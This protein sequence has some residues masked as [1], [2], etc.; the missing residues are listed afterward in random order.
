MI[1]NIFELSKSKKL[2]LALATDFFLLMLVNH[3]AI[4]YTFRITTEGSVFLY[5]LLLSAICMVNVALFYVIG[6]YKTVLRY[7]G[8]STPG[9][10]ILGSL[11]STAI[12]YVA[13]LFSDFETNYSFSTHASLLIISTYGY[14][15]VIWN[16]YQKIKSQDKINAAIYGAGEAGQTVVQLLKNNSMYHAAAILDDDPELQ[17]RTIDGIKVSSPKIAQKIIETNNIKTII[18][19]ISAKAVR[20]R[21]KIIK[22]M[23]EFGVQIKVLPSTADLLSDA[24]R[25]RDFPHPTVDELLGRD[26]VPPD[27]RLLRKA[28]SEKT[29]LVTGAGGTIGSEL[30]KQLIDLNPKK[31]IALDVS[32]AA[33]YQLNESVSDKFSEIPSTNNFQAVLGSILDVEMLDHLFSSEQITTVFHAA[34]YKHVPMVEANPI[35]GVMNNI[36]GTENIIKAIVKHR[37]SSMMLI[38]TDKAVRPTNIMGATKRVAELLVQK[39][40][41]DNPN[42]NFSAVRFGNVLGSSGSVVPKFFHQLNKG[43]QL[44]V[45]HPEITRYFMTVSEAAQLVIQASGLAKSGDI[46]HLD[47]GE[48]VKIIDLAKTIMDTYGYKPSVNNLTNAEG[49][50]PRIKIIG[51]RPGEKLYEELLV[52]GDELLTEHPKIKCEPFQAIDF[53]QVVIAT[54]ELVAEGN[55]DR[56]KMLFHNLPISYSSNAS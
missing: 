53:D 43:E 42:I 15:L 10:L 24:G 28:V 50:D 19:S 20:E 33:L 6:V 44:T 27:Q 4:Y 56:I 45:T 22:E 55:P 34:A 40:A 54:Q 16:I 5:T 18:I 49:Q 37:V 14:R 23:A 48:P 38:S 36:V 47:M 17:G 29:V 35:V 30:C 41:L 39:A 9:L 13:I 7:M 32:E 2:F 25:I 26:C 46:Y 3:Y 1:E 21:R 12:G 52:S 51:L 11:A 31:I 8:K